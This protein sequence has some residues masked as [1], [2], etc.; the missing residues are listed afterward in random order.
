MA[1]CFYH[2]EESR[3]LR[4]LR[5]L[6]PEAFKAFTDFDRIVFQEGELSQQVKEL[7][8]VATAHLT[9]CPYCIDVHTKRAKRAGATDGQIA[10]AIFVAMAL[11]AG[12]SF[13]HAAIAFRAAEEFEQKPPKS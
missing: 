13:A 9:Q 4:R 1:E 5:E 7:I 10:E 2:P 11:R 6:K 8:A 12:G 3:R